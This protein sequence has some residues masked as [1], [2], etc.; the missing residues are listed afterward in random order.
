MRMPILQLRHH[1]LEGIEHVE[2]RAGI[3]ICRGDG[4]GGMQDVEVADA[5]PRTSRGKSLLNRVRD[6]QDF[7]LPVRLD[8]E[9]F[10]GHPLFLA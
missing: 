9:A 4:R 3:Q 10:H 2:I 6:V 5:F 8:P 7:P 1:G